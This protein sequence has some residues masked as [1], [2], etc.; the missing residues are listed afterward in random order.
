MALVLYNTLSKKKEEFK[1]LNGKDVKIYVCGPTVYDFLHI[2]NFRGPVFFNLVRNWLENSG[3][4]VTYILNYTDVDDKIIQRANKEGSTQDAIANKYIAEYRKDF[5]I[6]GLRPH[7]RN[8][9]VTEFMK[10]IIVTI[11][12]LIANKK[13]YVVDG[14]VWCSVQDIPGYGK[15]SGKDLEGLI[16]GHRVEIGDKKKYPADFALWKKAKDGE[17]F[18]D[19]PWGKGRPGWHIECTAMSQTILGDTIDIH[20]GGVDLIFPHHENEIAQ[21]EGASGKD[22]VKYWMHWEFLN[23][24]QQK[25]SKSLGNV[26]TLRQ[27]VEKFHPEIYKFM[28]LLGHYR[29]KIDF[30]DVQVDH[31]ISGLARIYSTLCLANEVVK[32]GVK[33]DPLDAEFKKVLD[34]GAKGIETAL[35]D[36]FGTPE[37]MARLFESV[38]AFNHYQRGQKVTG[39]V[40]ARAESLIAWFKVYGKMMALFNEEP[41]DFLRFLDDMLLAKA[42]VKR[43]EV[44]G[45]VLARKEARKAKDFA[46]ADEVRNKLTGL[47]INVSDMPDGTSF[48]EVKK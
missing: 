2:G 21:S 13:A 35:N 5:E 19:S 36:D 32:S 26:V 15:L 7:D 46:K 41:H 44:D 11:E 33:A 48:W 39:K 6:L 9:R 4:K 14:D 16:A 31:A 18:W 23:F 24:S 40:V 25:M 42:N 28:I 45:L 8:P 17:P 10:E 43:E 47:N 38:R 22:F 29:K 1:P 20:G 12:K 37:V 27:F 34:D 3:Y 30:S